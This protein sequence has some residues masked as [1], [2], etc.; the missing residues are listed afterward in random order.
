M[1]GTYEKIDNQSADH[2]CRK[3]GWWSRR[4]HHAGVGTI[5]RC[6]CGRR[7]MWR[8]PHLLSDPMWEDMT[9]PNFVKYGPQIERIFDVVLG[10][11]WEVEETIRG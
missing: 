4:W 8:V 5:W 7:Y 9:A 3:P 1:S 10:P 6:E 11:S 2:E